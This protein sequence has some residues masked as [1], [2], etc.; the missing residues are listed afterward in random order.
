[1]KRSPLKHQKVKA[2]Q[3]PFRTLILLLMTMPGVGLLAAQAIL[4]EIGRDMTR[5][6]TAGHLLSWTGLCPSNNESAGKRRST[7]LRKGN[8]LLKTMLV[9]CAW[10]ATRKQG[11]YF[12]AQFYRI[13]ARDGVKKAACAVA[14]SILTT[15]Y[16]MLKD[17]TN[18]QDL[19]ADHFD[20]R[21]KQAKVN[22]LV[23]QLANLGFN[24]KLTAIPVGVS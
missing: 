23:T 5:F 10:A 7:R 4:S 11:S 2:G 16:H 6:P 3:A 1:L 8:L 13:R 22:R 15:I 14:A 18:F 17:G 9:Q 12:R 20:R 21:S 24:A 19:G